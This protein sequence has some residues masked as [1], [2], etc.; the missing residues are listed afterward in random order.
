VILH[1]GQPMTCRWMCSMRRERFMIAEIAA[2]RHNATPSGLDRRLPDAL[3]SRTSEAS[4]YQAMLPAPNH[5]S[6]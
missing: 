6:A 2:K 4:F 5:G 1:F 3:H